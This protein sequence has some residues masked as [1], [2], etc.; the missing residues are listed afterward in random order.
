METDQELTGGRV[1]RVYDPINFYFLEI[2][3]EEE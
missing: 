2:E 1:I 3:K